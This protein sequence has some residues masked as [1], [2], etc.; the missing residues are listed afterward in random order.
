MTPILKGFLTELANE[1]TNYAVQI[2]GGKG[3]LKDY[4]VE[5]LYRDSRLYTIHNG[6]TA[7]QV[8]I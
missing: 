4:W 2:H 5:Q 7:L 3:Y 8:N 1:A 6:P